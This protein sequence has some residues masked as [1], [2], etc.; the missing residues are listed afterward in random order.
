MSFGAIVLMQSGDPDSDEFGSLDPTHD[1]AITEIRVEQHLSKQTTF[2][3][4]FQEDFD[5]KDAAEKAQELFSKSRGIAI[6]V[7][8]GAPPEPG[9][10]IPADLRCLVRGQIE[11]AEF[12]INVGGSGS[13]FEIRGQDVRT[14]INR[15]NVPSQE[16]GDTKEIIERLVSPISK[17]PSV[18]QGIKKYEKNGLSF[19]YRGTDL[20]AVY[21]LTKKSAYC[22]WLT[23]DVMSL[24]PNPG[25]KITT[26][27]H[28]E[29]SPERE[30]SKGPP[31][32]EGF[33]GLVLGDTDAHK[34][35]IL[36]DA[37]SCETVVSFSVTSDNEAP[38]SATSYGQDLG[39]GT[40]SETEDA[41]SLDASQNNGPGVAGTGGTEGESLGKGDNQGDRCMTV[42]GNGEPDINQWLAFAAATE[43]SWYI[44]AE[45]LTSAHMLQGIVE[46]HQVLEV[47][48]GGCGVAG[49]YQATDVTHVINAVGHWMQVTLRSN[50]KNQTEELNL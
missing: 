7:A 16:N 37:E 25:F 45:A 21:D 42:G 14:R 47:D 44:R 11:N 50:S 26:K 8:N 13:W 4:R 12:H 17:S 31:S 23:Y 32:A 24:A 41:T 43:A 6:L 2:A 18:G 40:Q 20:E 29:A 1:S 28:I 49:K 46:P 39:D 34:F 35:S 5:D 3:I 36:G 22:F 10:P 19:N 15:Y 27:A 30:T 38:T 9:G 33:D 48:G